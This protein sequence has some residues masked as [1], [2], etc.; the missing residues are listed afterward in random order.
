MDEFEQNKR[1][2]IEERGTVVNDGEDLSPE[3]SDSEGSGYI[4]ANM[5]SGDYAE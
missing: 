1:F 4:D 5:D 3:A 2:V